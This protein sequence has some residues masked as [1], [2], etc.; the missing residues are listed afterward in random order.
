MDAKITKQRLGNLLAYDWL[1]IVVCIIAAVALLSIFFTMVGT[2][3]TNAQTFEV[4]SYTDVKTGSDFVRLDDALAEKKVFSY[5]ILETSWNSFSDNA[6]AGSAYS[7]RRAAGEGTAMFI[8]DVTETDE[9]GKVTSES[10][11]KIMTTRESDGACYGLYAGE[12][13]TGGFWDTQYYVEVWCK[14]YL[15]KF[16]NTENFEKLADFDARV[17]EHFLA[18]NGRDK[19]FRSAAKK[20]EG[21]ALE[22]ARIEGLKEDYLAV[23]AALEEGKLSYRKVTYS[24]GERCAAFDISGLH[25]GIDNLVYRAVDG[26]RSVDGVVLALFYNERGSGND[27]AMETLS[28]LRFLVEK[29]G[30]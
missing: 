24:D 16:Y 26:T 28:F 10:M 9:D 14:Q 19:R 13:Y 25:G 23:V 3:P 27:L 20:Q 5:D 15:A 22:K 8:T 30:V 11:L 18:R 4:Y 2:R 7:A 17:E 12:A 1:K 29:Y 21:I 6:Y